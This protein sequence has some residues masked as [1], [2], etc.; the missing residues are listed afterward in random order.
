MSSNVEQNGITVVCERENYSEIVAS[1]KAPASGQLSRKFVSSKVWGERV[2]R[3][4]I[5]RLLKS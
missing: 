5:Y 4:R 1:V 2:C 3:K